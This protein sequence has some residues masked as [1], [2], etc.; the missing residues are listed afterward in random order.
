MHVALD[1]FVDA[2]AVGQSTSQLQRCTLQLQSVL[3]FSQG[4]WTLPLVWVVPETR[5]ACPV[6]NAAA[7]MV[8]YR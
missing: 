1:G 3:F 8:N 2:A 6:L 5:M 7:H 4:S